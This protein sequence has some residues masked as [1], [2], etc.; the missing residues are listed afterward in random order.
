[1]LYHNVL[2]I[3]TNIYYGFLNEARKIWVHT[4]HYTVK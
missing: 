4:A 2:L 1:M 3:L